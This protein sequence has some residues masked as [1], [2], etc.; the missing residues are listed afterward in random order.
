M[1][2]KHYRLRAGRR[3]A[4]RQ[5]E[6]MEKEGAHP[7]APR[8]GV[9]IERAELAVAKPTGHGR[10]ILSCCCFLLV[11]FGPP[12]IGLGEIVRITVPPVE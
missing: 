9:R 8:G 10:V 2:T 12:P 7:V 11:G 3:K 4:K 1:R 5:A 6:A